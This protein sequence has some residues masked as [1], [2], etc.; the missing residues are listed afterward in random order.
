M[1]HKEVAELYR[2]TGALVLRRCRLLLHNTEAED[3]MQE[4]YIR[5]MR[6]GSFDN[7]TQ[8]PLAWLYRTAERC[9]FDRMR[10]RNREPVG[11]SPEMLEALALPGGGLQAEARELLTRFFSRLDDKLK[12]VALLHYLD[13][14]PQERIAEQLGWSRRTVGK[15]LDRLRKRAKR[16]SREGAR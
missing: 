11:L 13:G 12:Q 14:L 16:L 8:V 9:C 5:L 7:A 1:P 2:R 3:A 4:V 10:K 6:Y 15:K